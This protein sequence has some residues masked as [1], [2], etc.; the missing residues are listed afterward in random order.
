M[1]CLLANSQ[2]SDCSFA[3]P[4][5]LAVTVNARHNTLTEHVCVFCSPVAVYP[6]PIRGGDDGAPL[7][8]Y[9]LLCLHRLTCLICCF[10]PAICSQIFWLFTGS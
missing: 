10:S 1:H 6:D 8:H 4:L 9:A 5:V 2:R 3:G 7:S